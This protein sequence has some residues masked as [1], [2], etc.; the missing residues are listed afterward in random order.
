MKDLL[1]IIWA[2]LFLI[3]F[4]KVEAYFLFKSRQAFKELKN[5]YIDYK[6]AKKDLEEFLK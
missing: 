3:G 4:V 5:A 1:F 6:K 2:I